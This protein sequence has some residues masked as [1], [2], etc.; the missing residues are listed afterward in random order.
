MSD[1]RIIVDCEISPM[2]LKLGDP[3]PRVSV[4]FNDGAKAVLFEFYPDEIAFKENEFIGLTDS[5]ARQLYGRKDRE[6]LKR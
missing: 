6:Y 5:E 3:L 1:K 2:P 4:T